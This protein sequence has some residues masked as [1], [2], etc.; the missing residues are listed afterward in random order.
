MTGMIFLC[1]IGESSA[2]TPDPKPPDQPPSSSRP[3]L[4]PLPAEEDWS[5]LADQS[6]RTDFFDPA[7]YLQLKGDKPSRYLSFG[8]EYRTE[9][10]YYRNSTFGMGVQD[11]NG[12][13]L[14]R[15]M[16]HID[17]HLGPEVR[18]FSEFK[19]DFV[20]ARNGG[21][22][23]Q[24]DEDRGDVH[25][26]FLELGQHSII[27]R[28][29]SLRAGRQEITLGTG[30]LI[31]NNEGPN[32][33]LS[34]DGLRV[35]GQIGST[36]TD[37]FAVK[38][39]DENVGFFDDAPKHQQTLWGALFTIPVSPDKGVKADFYYLGNDYKAASYN[40][41]LP[42]RE[43][44]HTFGIRPFRPIGNGFD[45]NWEADLQIGRLGDHSIRAWAVSTESGYSIRSNRFHPR[46]VLRVDAFSGDRSSD[47]RAV[48]TFNP[49]FPR[50]AYFT[51]KVLPPVGPQNVIDLHPMLQFQ[52]RK[53]VTGEISWTRYWRNAALDGLYGFGNGTLI[54]AADPKARR[55][56]GQQGDLELRWA[57]MNHAI[58]AFNMFG[59]K[60]GG[61][62]SNQGYNQSPVA[63]NLGVTYRF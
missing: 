49:L 19:F 6:Q 26:A 41:R 60:T 53:D 47:G 12:Y 13:L 21:P 36:N 2:Q 18:F 28:S 39:V 30:R 51:P 56:L 11:Q 62:F 38:P 7:K 43:T 57:P 23:P 25:Q 32:V 17:L 27:P 8:L 4:T 22:R 54:Y 10:E 61:F 34:F 58:V 63:A 14:S 5:F 55:C 24:I 40:G 9:Y 1:L 3:P 44:R 59:F 29:W 37:L 15:V 45:Y 20:A 35:Q 52:L 50:G 16:P 31:D 42:A 48:G 46:P 33:K